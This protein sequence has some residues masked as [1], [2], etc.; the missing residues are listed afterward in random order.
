MEITALLVSD[1]TRLF[2]AAASFPIQKDADH[3]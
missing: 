3:G 2:D 1:V